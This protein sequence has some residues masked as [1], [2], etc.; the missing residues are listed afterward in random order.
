MKRNIT[1]FLAIISLISIRLNA[2]NLTKD[3]SRIAQESFYNNPI[4]RLNN[5][6]SSFLTQIQPLSL[7]DSY[8]NGAKNIPAIV[9]HSSSP[10]MRSVFYQVALECGQAGGIGY[11]FTYEMNRIRNLHADVNANLYP[12][13]FAW[14]FKNGGAGNGVNCLETWDVLRMAGTPN[15]AQWGGTLSYGG[16]KRWISGYSNYYDAMKN[17]VFETYSIPVN[18]IEGLQTLKYWLYDHLEGSSEGG[19]ANFYSTYVSNGAT[20]LTLPAGTPEGGMKVITQ[21]GSYVNHCQTIVGFNDSI[22]YDYNGDG[23]YTNN[24]DITN[25]GIV[26]M[27]DWEIGGVKFT[28]SFG[29]AFADNGYC[30]MMY[31]VLAESLPN[32]GIWNNQ[33][34]VI[35]VKENYN[36]LATFKVSLTHPARGR[37]KVLA[38]ISTNLAAMVPE[39][40]MEFSVF[41]YQGGDFYMQ[42]DTIEAAKTIEFGL[43]I[44]PILNDVVPGTSTKYFF[45][46]L[47]NDGANSYNGQINSFSVIDYTSGSAIEIASTQTNVAIINNDITTMDATATINHQKPVIANLTLPI[48]EAYEAYQEQLTATAGTAPYHWRFKMGYD[49]SEQAS[50]FPSVTQQSVSMSATHDGYATKTL[51]FEFP[52]YGKK[53]DKIVINTGGYIEFR[54]NTYTWPFL[55]STDLLFKSH[56][57]IAPFKAD[58]IMNSGDGIW[59]ESMPT[60]AIVRWKMSVSGQSG[61]QVNVAVKLFPSGDIEFYYGNINV[62]STATWRAGISRGNAKDLSIPSISSSFATNTVE[63]KVLFDKYDTPDMLS[64]SDDGLLTGT[65]SEYYNNLP[66]H[67]QVIDNNELINEKTLPFSTSFSNRIVVLSHTEHAGADNIVNN[68][69]LTKV[70]L[71]IK[72][73][74]TA[75]VTNAQIVASSTDPYITF[76][77][78]SEYFGYIGA[79]NTYTLSNAIKFEVSP[80]IPNEHPIHIKIQTLCDGSPSTTNIVI[81]AFSSNVDFVSANVLDGNDNTL[82][83]NETDT[84]AVNITNTGGSTISNLQGMLST[85]EPNIA[86]VQNLDSIESL[87]PFSTA[88]LRYVVVLNSAFEN[89]RMNDFLLNLSAENFSK[90]LSFSLFS[91]GIIEDFETGDFSQYPWVLSDTAWTIRTDSVFEGTHV[92]RSGIITH[93]QTSIMSLTEDILVPGL[94]SF[95]KKVSCEDDGNNNWDYLA[96]SIDG[97]E[98]ERW[99]GE[100]DWGQHAYLVTTGTHTFSWKY[101]KDVSVNSGFDAAWV[102]YILFPMFGSSNPNCLVAPDSIHKYLYPT[103]TANFKLYLTNTASGTAT[104]Q[105]HILDLDGYN[106]PW[107]NPLYTSGSV[108]S[109]ESDSIPV[110]IL[111]NNMI[112]G[113]YYATIN[114]SYSNG[115]QFEIPV[116][117]TVLL[118]DGV[119]ENRTKNTI[120]VYPNPAKDKVTFQVPADLEKSAT[121]SI[122]SF[123]GQLIETITNSTYINSEKAYIWEPSGLAAGIYYYE[124]NS[125]QYS[126]RGKFSLIP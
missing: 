70:D 59:F 8:K 9:D 124:I 46:T 80:S 86:F 89:G 31:K 61:S 102:D 36:P 72:N 118:N 78:N 53:Y 64:L 17:R 95:Y 77:D 57:L 1:F 122:Y 106:V 4:S 62:S 60:Y 16:S 56:E 66:I 117:L 26:D 113:E 63:K 15:V 25:D 24:L 21:F 11:T 45:Q 50:S 37:L 42:G 87:A 43:D 30:Y 67:I 14:N 49:Q 27:R 44:S 103:E 29:S 40:T 114:V 88:T 23:M 111:P 75:A 119:A 33:V 83:A 68:G 104:Y 97:I 35:N 99:D 28:N 112:P 71:E 108:N 93:Y 96:F 81:I 109:N 121:V 123:T 92:A 115:T 19:I 76:T 82:N 107:I 101:N 2:Q 69:E 85:F 116:H 120:Q 125:N 39:K 91:G 3:A 34:F 54:N 94:V 41:N 13:H 20:F 100:I 6:D 65:P 126:S 38:G 22:R 58:L 110:S 48:A 5:Q 47:E 74:D 51:P 55:V 98:K 32:G 12:T 52:F 10:F 73:I 18:T 105:L 90:T 84:I 7:P 79:G